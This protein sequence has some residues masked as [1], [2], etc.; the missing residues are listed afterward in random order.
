MN[1]ETYKR[2]AK[3]KYIKSL[4]T[5]VTC[6]N[7]ANKIESSLPKGWKI[8]CNLLFDQFE[9][10]K[11][12]SE[13]EGADAHEFKLV[14]KLLESVLGEKIKNRYGT[15][16]SNKVVTSLSACGYFEV[17][18]RHLSVHV[19]M[20]NPENMPDC[21]VTFKRTWKKEAVISD[22]CLGINGE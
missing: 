1:I 2:S 14:C 12:G 3:S 5:I 20:M 7:I 4:R 13:E 11:Y 17:N 6:R 18:R 15:A 9:V 21:E 16:L 19:C 22:A 10:S 8:N